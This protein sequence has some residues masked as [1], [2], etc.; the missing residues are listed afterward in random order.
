LCGGNEPLI[1]ERKKKT[2]CP[3]GI[4]FE[5]TDQGRGQVQVLRR[6]ASNEPVQPGP[7]RQLASFFVDKAYGSVTMSMDFREGG[8]HT[9]SL[10]KLCD[11]L[12]E[13]RVPY[14]VRSLK[15]SDYGKITY[16]LVFA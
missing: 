4:L 12:D 10:H 16:I 14:V 8:G 15:I 5:L 7:L 1:K 11:L 6:I 13:Y 3:S 2:S 9:K